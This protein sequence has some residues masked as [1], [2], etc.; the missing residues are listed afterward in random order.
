MFLY[1]HEN[2]VT[3]CGLLPYDTAMRSSSMHAAGSQQRTLGVSTSDVVDTPLSLSSSCDELPFLS[4]PAP[5]AFA[6]PARGETSDAGDF[7]PV[8]SFVPPVIPPSLFFSRNRAGERL[9]P[10]PPFT[11]DGPC[12]LPFSAFFAPAL[13]PADSRT[14]LADPPA[15]G[16]SKPAFFGCGWEALV[17]LAAPTPALPAAD[18]AFGPPPAA[19]P[20]LLLALSRSAAAF[21][22]SFSRSAD[23]AFAASLSR[24]LCSA[25]GVG[26]ESATRKSIRVYEPACTHALIAT[27]TVRA[28]L[29][30]KTAACQNSSRLPRVGMRATVLEA[31]TSVALL[32]SFLAH[33]H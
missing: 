7:R 32:G 5:S 3:L 31:P 19:L 16:G 8:A 30:A 26:Q 21:A 9:P 24:S 13:T 12:A 6:F 33:Q 23:A 4:S 10:T 11:G 17:T 29:P 22:L 1:T 18:V 14:S 27:A 25:R 2:R 28:Q 15:F 20:F